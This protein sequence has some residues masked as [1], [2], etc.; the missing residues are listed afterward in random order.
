MDNSAAE[1]L[2]QFE[3]AL[4]HL[5]R[6][7][8]ELNAIVIRQDKQ[9]ARLTAVVDRVDN[10]LRNLEMDEVRSNNQRPPHYGDS[11]LA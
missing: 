3:A 1:R 8:D 9:L 10:A 11:A 7:Y 5:E 2:K 4:T 6:Q